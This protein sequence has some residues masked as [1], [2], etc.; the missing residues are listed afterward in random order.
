[1]Q[2]ILQ[3]T[4]MSAIA[5]TL[6]HGKSSTNTTHKSTKNKGT[7]TNTYTLFAHAGVPFVLSLFHNDG[8]AWMWST[9]RVITRGPLE[10]LNSPTPTGKWA[11][12]WNKVTPSNGNDEGCTHRQRCKHIKHQDE[13]MQAHLSASNTICTALSLSYNHRHN[14]TQTWTEN[15]M[16]VA[17]YTVD[18]SG[19]IIISVSDLKTRLIKTLMY[20]YIKLTKR[21]AINKLHCVTGLILSSHLAAYW[22]YF[23]TESFILDLHS[24]DIDIFFYHENAKFNSCENTKHTAKQ[25]KNKKIKK[26]TVIVHST[27]F[28]ADDGTHTLF[29]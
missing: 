24:L 19:I 14:E 16:H 11:P 12:Q 13:Q 7:I 23:K 29:Q 20:G 17:D 3:Y 8:W 27:L 22:V 1:M 4:S 2:K 26:N 25:L 9:Y 18:G 15:S 6:L 10:V 28:S 5:C 21:S